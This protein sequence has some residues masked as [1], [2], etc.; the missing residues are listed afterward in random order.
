MDSLEEI[1]F[2]GIDVINFKGVIKRSII[3]IAVMILTLA[4][5]VAAAS[6]L[7]VKV[8]DFSFVSKVDHTEVIGNSAEA[9]NDYKEAFFYETGYIPSGY[10][11]LSE[12]AFEDVSLDRVYQNDEGDCI[13]IEQQRADNYVANID[14]ESCTVNTKVIHEM[15]NVIYD[16]GNRKTYMMQEE[17]T[18]I[19]ITGIISDEEFEKI[20]CGLKFN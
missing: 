15:E 4:L 5:F 3:V 16:Y 11:L 20:I 9:G 7:G 6:A 12:D 17:N 18:V 13:Y 14:N 10:A 8:F 2:T 1:P 19:V